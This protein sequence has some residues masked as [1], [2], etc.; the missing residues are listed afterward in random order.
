VDLE[1]YDVALAER[2]H[3]HKRGAPALARAVRVDGAG[4]DEII[5]EHGIVLTSGVEQLTM[6]HGA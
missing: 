2:R 3:R 4:E 5:G 6:G 1:G